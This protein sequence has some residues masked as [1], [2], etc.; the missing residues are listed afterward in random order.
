M[1]QCDRELAGRVV[2]NS[3]SGTSLANSAAIYTWMNWNT[4]PDSGE[5]DKSCD[6]CSKD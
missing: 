4:F 6:E 5:N 2:F 3:N 1:T